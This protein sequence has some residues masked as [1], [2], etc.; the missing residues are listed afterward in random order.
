MT[1]VL[2]IDPSINNCGIAVFKDGKLHAWELLHPSKETKDYIEK[3]KSIY[4]QIK[5]LSKKYH[6]DYIVTEICDYF[7]VSGFHARESGSIF[8]LMFLIGM[9]CSLP[10]VKTIIPRGWKG[11]LPKD[12]MRRRFIKD[13]P[14]LD[15]EHMDHNVL[16]AIGIG[17]W[18]I[19][20]GL[21]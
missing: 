20:K 17:R 14:N 11:Q 5:V 19:Q 13:L 2:A 18:F 1:T 16:D 7:G 12:V 8:K 4:M 3:S 21:V 9:L 6:C 15:I 10:N